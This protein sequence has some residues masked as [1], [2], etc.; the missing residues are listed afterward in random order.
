MTTFQV[1]PHSEADPL[2]ALCD[3][4]VP[5]P[6]TREEP[7][8]P[9]SELF[10]LEAGTSDGDKLKRQWAQLDAPAF[11]EFY[12][13]A[14]NQ[15][16]FD[17]DAEFD[18]PVF[19]V[20]DLAGEHSRT[21]L[22]PAKGTQNYSGLDSF[23]PMHKVRKSLDES[24]C[25]RFGKSLKARLPMLLTGVATT[26]AIFLTAAFIAQRLHHPHWADGFLLLIIISAILWLG[27]ILDALNRL[28]GL[29]EDLKI[30]ASFE[31]LLPQHVRQKATDLRSQFEQLFLVTDQRGR[32]TYKLSPR[33][34]P[35]NIDPLLIG[36]K[37]LTDGIDHYYL[38]DVFELTRA[39]E[40]LASEFTTGHP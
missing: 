8:L 2:R 31:G 29:S 12:P 39:E 22:L 36:K 14:L 15:T 19:A 4:L 35:P 33:P 21:Y 23:L 5:P 16:Y 30:T 28:E 34:L 6:Q 20:F 10:P 17:K 7:T 38:I 26:G 13:E 1:Q 9:I 24:I 11:P 32:W 3:Q 37:K 18:L 27:M 40:Y 25:R